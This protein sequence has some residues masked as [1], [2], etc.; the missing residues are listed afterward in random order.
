MLGPQTFIY[1]YSVINQKGGVGKT[2]TALAL[3]Q[4]LA[5]RGCKVLAIDLDPQGNMSYSLGSQSRGYGAMEVLEHPE[6]VKGIIEHITPTLDLI[7]SSAALAEANTRLKGKDKNVRLLK[8]LS[9]LPD[10]KDGY[11]F[12]IIDT[13]PALGTLTINALTA[14]NACIIPTLCD[15]YSFQGIKQLYTTIS[16]VQKT[17]NT[18]LFIEGIL[19][20]RYNNRITLRREIEEQLEEL[21]KMYDTKILNTHIRENIAL[22]EAQALKQS[23]FTYSPE[24]NGAQDYSDLVDEL[25]T[26]LKGYDTWKSGGGIYTAVDDKLDKLN[27]LEERH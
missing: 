22:A 4:Q 5:L 15:I 8:A 17:T 2:T 9:Y 11:R 1:T 7:P 26:N 25:L 6:G 19:L 27:K 20:I 18:N 10:L 14:T 23:I 3:A 13:P 24:S 21:V 12:C 16:V